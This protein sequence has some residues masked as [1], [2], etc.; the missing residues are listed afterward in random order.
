M[1]A[2]G[3]DDRMVVLLLNLVLT[4]RLETSAGHSV[5]LAAPWPGVC[6]V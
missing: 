4:L 2:E 3:R 1:F 5:C 6:R